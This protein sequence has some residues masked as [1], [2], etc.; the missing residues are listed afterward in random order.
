MRL[1]MQQLYPVWRGNL[2]SLYTELNL[3]CWGEL[4][5]TETLKTACFGPC[6]NPEEHDHGQTAGR[7][8]WKLLYQCRPVAQYSGANPHFKGKH[9]FLKHLGHICTEIQLFRIVGHSPSPFNAHI[10]FPKA[11]EQKER[12]CLRRALA[13]FVFSEDRL[14]TLS[15]FIPSRPLI[16]V[17]KNLQKQKKS[18]LDLLCTWPVKILPDLL[19]LHRWTW[20]S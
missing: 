3:W 15:A 1:K 17:L 6:E 13:G 11:S 7:E 16:S 18:I 9:V 20:L 19:A 5:T 10:I 2:C 4:L 14:N 8:T 12:I